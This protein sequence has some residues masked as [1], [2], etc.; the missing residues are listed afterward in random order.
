[1]KGFDFACLLDDVGRTQVVAVY[2]SQEMGKALAALVEEVVGSAKIVDVNV[3]A[4]LVTFTGR[5][6]RVVVRPTALIVLPDPED[7]ESLERRLK[8]AMGGEG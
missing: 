5:G 1:M 4:G 3:P 8:E 2:E 6:A 7:M